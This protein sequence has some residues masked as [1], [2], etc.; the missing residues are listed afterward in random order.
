MVQNSLWHSF[1]LHLLGNDVALEINVINT[2][3]YNS[4]NETGSDIKGDK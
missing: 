2:M 4:Y 3:I 1:F